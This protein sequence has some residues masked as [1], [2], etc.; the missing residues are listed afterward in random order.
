MTIEARQKETN[1]ALSDTKQSQH[2]A[3]RDLTKNL[4]FRNLSGICY[5][6]PALLQLDFMGTG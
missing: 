3:A 5:L 6:V 1:L 2:F 4:E